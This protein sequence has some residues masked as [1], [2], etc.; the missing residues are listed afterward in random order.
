VRIHLQS[1][2]PVGCGMGSSA[3]TILCI[4]HALACYLGMDVS[5]EFFLRLGIEAENLQHG[6]SSGLDLRICQEGGCLLAE[7]GQFMLRPIPTLFPLYLVN[8][9]APITTTG[10]CVAAVRHHFAT[11]HLVDAFAA[12]TYAI[13]KTFNGNPADKNAFSELRRAVR[14]NHILLDHIGVVPEKVRAFIA[15]IEQLGGAA[16]ICGSGAV[17]GQSAGVLLLILETTDQL[18]DLC[19]QYGYYYLPVK[20]DQRGIHTLCPQRLQKPGSRNT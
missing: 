12:V 3:A 17:S 13:D 6:Y 2:I 11:P 16:K 5:R 8:T 1:D 15:A 14:K 7:N 18:A 10:E 9:G 19:K 4:S 20:G